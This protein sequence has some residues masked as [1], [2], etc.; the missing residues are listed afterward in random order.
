MINSKAK[1]ICKKESIRDLLDTI[2]YN[3]ACC[4]SLKNELKKYNDAMR[5]AIQIPYYH[6]KA[7][8][9]ED[10]ENLRNDSK[11]EDLFE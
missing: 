11:Y 7:K 5:Y 10:L 9:D 3:L 4:Y 2:E 8:T 6:K 1:E